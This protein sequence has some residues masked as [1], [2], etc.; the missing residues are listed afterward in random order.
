MA[1]CPW[2]DLMAKAG[3]AALSERVGTTICSAENRV[4]ASEF[5]GEISF[6]LESQICKGD[7]ACVLRFTKSH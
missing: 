3:R 1:R 4:W 5:E 2:H 7:P 6:G